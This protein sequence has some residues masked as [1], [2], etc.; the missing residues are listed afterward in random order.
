MKISKLIL[1]N[2]Y[3]LLR[4]IFN[5][6]LYLIFAYY[7]GYITI[8]SQDTS[9]GALYLL[10]G[11]IILCGCLYY[12]YLKYHYRKMIQKLTMETNIP[13]SRQLQEKLLEQDLFK[14]F[15][16]SIIIFEALLLFDEGRYRDCLWHL[17]DHQRFFKSSTDYLFIYYYNQLLCY[18]YL[19]KQTEG[20][21]VAQKLM[22]L[23]NLKKKS[24]SP[25]FSWQEIQGVIYGLQGRHQ[26]AL[27]EYQLVNHQAMNP[28]EQAHLYMLMADSFREIGQLQDFGHYRK[29]AQRLAPTFQFRKVSDDEKIPGRSQQTT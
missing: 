11:S 14:G 9:A 29:K 25:L 13:A 24:Y 19:N 23:K 1:W 27:K 4:F 17:E 12:E 2:S 21:A 22:Q 7:I 15:K 5:W 10:V 3:S 26:K 18:Y 20:L 6:G 8:N 16:Q 28:R